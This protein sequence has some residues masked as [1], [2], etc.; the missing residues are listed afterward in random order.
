MFLRLLVIVCF[1]LANPCCHAAGWRHN[2]LVGASGI[3]PRQ[4]GSAEGVG[5]SMRSYKDAVQNACYWG[6]RT[7]VSIQYS[8][9]G[10]RY[11][12]VVRYK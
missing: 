12:A 10:G 8:Y 11:Y 6:Q 5:M 1:L 9:R 4:V 3:T 2:R 7:P